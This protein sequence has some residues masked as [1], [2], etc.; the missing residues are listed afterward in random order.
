MFPFD[1]FAL[2][3]SVSVVLSVNV[4]A[5]V[6]HAVARVADNRDLHAA[7]VLLIFLYENLFEVLAQTLKVV[8]LGEGLFKHSRLHLNG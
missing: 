3:N 7:L 2:Q 6:A 5:L 1:A 8:V 4:A